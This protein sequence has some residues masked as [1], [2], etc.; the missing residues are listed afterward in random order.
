VNEAEA[1]AIIERM[2]T[3]LRSACGEKDAAE[4]AKLIQRVIELRA[5]C[6]QILTDAEYWNANV[7][8]PSEEPVDPDPDG[9]LALLIEK[10][11]AQVKAWTS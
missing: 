6:R 8:K 5:E 9:T 2:D 4:R 11:D 3:R 10:L 7:R 1:R